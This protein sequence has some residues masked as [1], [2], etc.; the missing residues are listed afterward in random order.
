ML[1]V[2]VVA[3]DI[4][5]TGEN[6]IHELN[7]ELAL[8]EAAE[9]GSCDNEIRAAKAACGE[10]LAY[11]KKVHES[12]CGDKD[13][14][15]VMG[16]IKRNHARTKA[17]QRELA[18]A[19][20]ALRKGKYA[21]QNVSQLAKSSKEKLIKAMVTQIHQKNAL[22]TDAQLA[23]DELKDEKSTR[24][25]AHKATVKAV[26]LAKSSK[27]MGPVSSQAGKAK[28][29]YAKMVEEKVKEGRQ[30]YKAK[31]GKKQAKVTDAMVK[32][33]FKKAKE[34]RAKEQAQLKKVKKET[35]KVAKENVTL[36]Q[37]EKK[38]AIMEKDASKKEKSNLKKQV[39]KAK[40]VIKKDQAKLK[41]ANN[42]LSLA[43]KD[44]AT[45]TAE[46]NKLKGMDLKA[47]L[48]QAGS[49]LKPGKR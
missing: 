11:F 48:S 25:K 6:M 38:T 27:D 13:L 22:K 47:L 33:L 41:T 20:S 23:I 4:S 34:A 46:V 16:R 42:N 29:L 35:V 1:T 12:S 21:E 30:K 24:Y 28:S 31:G 5:E 17:Q 8:V 49:L 32:K 3:V 36:S 40:V 10:R 9:Q 2:T 19:E 26:K 44:S 45:A 14:A 39:D 43:K 15:R 37:K 7:D 18:R